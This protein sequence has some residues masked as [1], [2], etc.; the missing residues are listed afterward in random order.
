MKQVITDI[1]EM[2]RLLWHLYDDK[3][4]HLKGV[5]KFLEAFNLFK[6]DYGIHENRREQLHARKLKQ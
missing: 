5:D 1:S 6:G 2:Q 4:G 3:L